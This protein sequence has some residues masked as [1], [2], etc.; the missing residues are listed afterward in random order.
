[1]HGSS[2]S[3]TRRALGRT[4]NCRQETLYTNTLRVFCLLAPRTPSVEWRVYIHKRAD[5]SQLT[6]AR[7]RCQQFGGSHFAEI[8]SAL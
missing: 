2:F 8:A 3:L 4:T 1:M 7:S 5:H 6:A